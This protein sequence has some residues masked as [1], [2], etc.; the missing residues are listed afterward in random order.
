MNNLEQE[1]AALKKQKA[2]TVAFLKRISKEAGMMLGPEI[3]KHLAT[4]NGQSFQPSNWNV[5]DTN[6]DQ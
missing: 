6:G 4:L 3:D 5:A 1:N 2:E